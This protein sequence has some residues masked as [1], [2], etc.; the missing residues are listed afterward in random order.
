MDS[1]PDDIVDIPELPEL[2]L[3]WL[4][5]TGNGAVISGSNPGAVLLND[6]VFMNGSRANNNRNIWRYSVT[7]NSMSPLSYPSCALDVPTN[8]QA[9]TV[10]QSQLLWIGT[11][12]E[13]SDEIKVFVLTHS[14]QETMHGI[15]QVTHTI[16][17]PIIN[18][19]SATSEG[20]YLIIVI[21]MRYQG[22]TVLLFDGEEW[23]KIDIPS[24]PPESAYGE[25]DIIIHNGILYLCTHVGFY[26]VYLETSLATNQFSW[27]KLTFAPLSRHHSNFT[28]FDG[29]IVA[30]VVAPT[31]KKSQESDA[32]YG[33]CNNVMTVFAY[34]S[35]DDYWLALKKLECHLCWATP[36]IMGLPIGCLL[37]LG[38]TPDSPQFNILEVRIAKG[39]STYLYLEIIS[40]I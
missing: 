8:C 34:Q 22:M 37:I 5:C 35:T 14:W 33:Y 24:R 36:S 19:I 27:K 9:L 16:E 40:F 20:K 21:S 15:P 31:T 2:T 17:S 10:Y 25:T 4:N 1:D 39:I 30:V 13:Y 7:G 12:D 18:F 28:L 32:Y 6:N 29:H 3:R 23:K 38:V 11:C 26:M